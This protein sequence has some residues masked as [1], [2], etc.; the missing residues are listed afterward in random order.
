MTS[1]LHFNSVVKN[2]FI[3]FVPIMKSPVK[4][5]FCDKESKNYYSQQLDCT[6][7]I[8]NVHWC[9]D[10]SNNN[11]L[12]F[13][14]SSNLTLI[15]LAERM[16]F[17]AKINLYINQSLHIDI[18]SEKLNDCMINNL[19]FLSQKYKTGICIIDEAI[20]IKFRKFRYN[21]N[22]N[23]ESLID[24]NVTLKH[25]TILQDNGLSTSQYILEKLKPLFQNVDKINFGFTF[26]GYNNNV[27]YSNIHHVSIMSE[28]YIYS[29]NIQSFPKFVGFDFGKILVSIAYENTLH[30]DLFTFVSSDIIDFINNNIVKHIEHGGM[31]CVHYSSYLNNN[32]MLESLVTSCD[33][34]CAD[35]MSILFEKCPS[36]ISLHLIVEDNYQDEDNDQNDKNRQILFTTLASQT[37]LINLGLDIF[38]ENNGH[39]IEKYINILFDSQNLHSLSISHNEH[40]FEIDKMI[41]SIVNNTTLGKIDISPC[42]TNFENLQPLITKCDKDCDIILDL[43]HTLKINVECL[44]N[45]VKKNPNNPFFGFL[46]LQCIHSINSRVY[47][48]TLYERCQ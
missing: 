11:M 32:Q 4:V 40:I 47:N 30:E 44:N 8:I 28:E 31:D 15:N 38:A 18:N 42:T 35:Y 10:V 37:N 21:S 34:L 7:D 39:N 41:Q 16:F 6:K 22:N 45:L 48:K 29:D 13:V 14:F 25:K 19:F 27:T 3:K 23:I 46:N 24:L 5:Q 17:H 2:V 36:L 43:D 9:E 20:I 33:L 1:P 26:N 12:Y